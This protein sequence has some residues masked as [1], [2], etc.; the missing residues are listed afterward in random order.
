ML[1]SGEYNPHP[2]KNA[3][4]CGKADQPPSEFSGAVCCLVTAK[5]SNIVMLISGR[6][7]LVF[8]R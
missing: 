6:C 7:D 8:W 5:G 1:V 3:E 4:N 2:P